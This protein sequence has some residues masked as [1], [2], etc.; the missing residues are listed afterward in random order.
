MLIFM[1]Q[2]R[3]E[4]LRPPVFSSKSMMKAFERTTALVIRS[5]DDENK[6][7]AGGVLIE[8]RV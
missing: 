4:K 3:N 7:E 6:M 8:S 2:L 5:S 1:L